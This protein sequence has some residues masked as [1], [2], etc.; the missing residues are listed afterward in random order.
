M[1]L[2]FNKVVISG[3]QIENMEIKVRVNGELTVP[4]I[5]EVITE[6]YAT[7][8]LLKDHICPDALRLEFH[9]NFIELYEI[10]VF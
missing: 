1:E 5:A 9:N 6:K 7:T 4:E 10:E 2:S 3:H 8:F